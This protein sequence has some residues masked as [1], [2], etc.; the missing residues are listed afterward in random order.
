[1]NNIIL[2]GS[3]LPK[4]TINDIKRYFKWI[5]IIIFVGVVITLLIIYLLSDHKTIG[6]IT[7]H[8]ITDNGKPVDLKINLKD[9][10]KFNLPDLKYKHNIIIDGFIKPRYSENYKFTIPNVYNSTTLTIND[11]L[12]M[13]VNKD[14]A[15]SDNGINLIKDTWVPIK[16]EQKIEDLNSNHLEFELNWESDTEQKKT[17][18]VT[19]IS[20]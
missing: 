12:I 1:M 5:P 15:V 18:P 2:H 6:I 20:K 16:I 19:L 4:H 7:I 9:N 14:K 17:I 8:Y 3:D 10:F 13:D 11:Q